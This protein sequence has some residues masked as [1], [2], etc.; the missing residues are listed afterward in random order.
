MISLAEITFRFASKFGFAESSEALSPLF[1]AGL[2]TDHASVAV[3]YEQSRNAY[4][5][6]LVEVLD[7][8]GSNGK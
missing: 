7:L 4:S 2:S 3:C 6:A 5:Q 8:G 1:I